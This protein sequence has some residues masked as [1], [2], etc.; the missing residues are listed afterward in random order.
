MSASTITVKQQSFVRSLLEERLDALGI[1]DIDEYIK[2]QSINTLTGQGASKLIDAL[3]SIPCSK[4]PEH[5]HL[6]EGRVIANRYG[7]KC[8]LCNSYVEA[9]D[10][11]A[12]QTAGGWRTFH[13]AGAC[14]V[15]DESLPTIVVESGKTYRLEDGTIA[16]AYTTQNKRLASRRLVIES[17]GTGHLEYW[18]GGIAK[19]KATG[20]L[21]TQ[22]EASRIG[23]LHRFCVSCC[24]D[25]SDD[26]SLASG[27]GQ[28]CAENNGWWY[29]SLKEAKEILQR[30]VTL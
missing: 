28:T 2:T 7:N 30:D 5:A 25:L 15:V 4:K 23:R 17:D 29:A 14:V 6:P 20:A 19:I 10:G 11:W 8:T 27:Y 22:E 24:R 18:Q 26:R 9:G 3:K 21:L 16:V 12:V 13:G 1:T